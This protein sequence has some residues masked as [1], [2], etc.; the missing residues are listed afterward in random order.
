MGGCLFKSPEKIF[1]K[2]LAIKTNPLFCIANH[3]VLCYNR[4][5][6]VPPPP[7]TTTVKK[8]KKKK[9]LAPGRLYVINDG[10]SIANRIFRSPSLE[11]FQEQKYFRN[12][13]VFLHLETV[14]AENYGPEE[15]AYLEHAGYKKL[16]DQAY[17]NRGVCKFLGPDGRVYFTYN[18]GIRDHFS[19]LFQP[20]T[21][22]HQ[23]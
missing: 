4:M 10:G 17:Y 7:T 11:N 14:M 9:I 19:R 16:Y 13:E 12:G 21:P 3:L 22:T 1:P 6:I 2:F 18:W 20:P 15:I 5:M 23:K 8:K